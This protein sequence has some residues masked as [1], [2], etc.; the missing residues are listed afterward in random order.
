M[1]L[2]AQARVQSMLT[3]LWF[4][5]AAVAGL[6]YCGMTRRLGKDTSWSGSIAL[7]LAP[8]LLV[9]ITPMAMAIEHLNPDLCDVPI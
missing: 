7:G 1:S 4:T 6:G 3:A 8:A 5:F 9:P 2:D